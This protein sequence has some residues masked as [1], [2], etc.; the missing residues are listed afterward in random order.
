MWYWQVTI[1]GGRP[2]LHRSVYWHGLPLP[3]ITH[4]RPRYGTAGAGSAGRERG[5][6]FGSKEG[7]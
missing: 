7:G 4:P 2:Y 3:H 5:W 1:V 6:S